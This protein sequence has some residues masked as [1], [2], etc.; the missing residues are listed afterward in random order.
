[1][2]AGCPSKNNS[3]DSPN[4]NGTS[5]AN[6]G[7]TPA[8][9]PTPVWARTEYIFQNKTG[10]QITIRGTGW[11]VILNADECVYIGHL[12]TSLDLAKFIKAGKGQL[13]GDSYR[14]C[15]NKLEA[16]RTVGGYSD[17]ERD[18]ESQE[19]YMEIYNIVDSDNLFETVG[20]PFSD[21]SQKSPWLTRCKSRQAQ[22]TC[23]PDPEDPRVERCQSPLGETNPSEIISE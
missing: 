1:M 22:V 12:S 16:S 4:T 3:N 13:C 21:P 23:S 17:F 6:T 11:K 2:L 7:G 9:V 20:S 19:S 15:S 5:N 10:A 14:D 18:K 8:G